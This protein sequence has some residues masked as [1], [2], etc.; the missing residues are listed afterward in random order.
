MN[1]SIFDLILERDILNAKIKRNPPNVKDLLLER[2]IFQ[3]KINHL[4]SKCPH[5]N[6]VW[7]P[8]EYQGHILDPG[9]ESYMCKDCGY[10]K[11]GL[12]MTRYK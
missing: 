6:M 5:E 4:K 10:I 12:G 1:E 2:D 9:D 8:D 11:L 3:L 7:A